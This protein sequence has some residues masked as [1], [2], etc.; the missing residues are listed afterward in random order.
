[1]V[2]PKDVLDLLIQSGI[3][4]MEERQSVMNKDTAKERCRALID[5]LLCCSKEIAF[6]IFREALKEHYPSFAELLETIDSG[7]K[8][9]DDYRT[10]KFKISTRAFQVESIWVALLFSLC[11]WAITL[12]L[13]TFR[14]YCYSL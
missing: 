2:D 1:M 7:D 4:S 9:E 12:H 8:N 10:G 6:V 3:V 5:H 13:N 14:L 11:N